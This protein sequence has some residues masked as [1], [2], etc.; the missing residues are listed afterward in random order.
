MMMPACPRLSSIASTMSDMDAPFVTLSSTSL[1]ITENALHN[2]LVITSLLPSRLT[3]QYVHSPPL[4]LHVYAPSI[5]PRL[6]VIIS[7][8][9]F[10]Q[11]SLLGAST[12]SLEPTARVTLRL[13]SLFLSHPTP[14]VVV[15]INKVQR[16]GHL[17]F[18][19]VLCVVHRESSVAHRDVTTKP[20]HR[21]P[22]LHTCLITHLQADGSRVSALHRTY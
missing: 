1:L 14:P 6:S 20:L 21:R 4:R 12:R 9:L 3:P 18:C 2:A 15:N 5:Y 13:K 22:R 19:L 11:N 7:M 10:S 8:S 17:P 16:L